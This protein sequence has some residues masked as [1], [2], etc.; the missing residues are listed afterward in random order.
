VSEETDALSDS[1]SWK[2]CDL[3]AFLEAADGIRT[4]DL[5]HGKQSA[6]V[7]LRRQLPANERFLAPLADRARLRNVGD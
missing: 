2:A 6:H 7:W 3:Q 5:L 4:H 1:L